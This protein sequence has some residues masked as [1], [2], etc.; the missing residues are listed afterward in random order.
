VIKCIEKYLLQHAEA[1]AA[2]IGNMPGEFSHLVV[3]PAFA[4]P[5]AS[6]AGIIASLSAQAPRCLLIL[7]VN[8]PQTVSE[9]QLQI[10]ANLVHRLSE[11]RSIRWQHA[12]LSLLE[13]RD[14]PILLVKR[15]QPGYRIA[16]GEG[17]G[18]ARK[19]GADIALQLLALQRCGCP[20]IFSTDADVSLPR[21]YL[22]APKQWADQR[23]PGAPSIKD[24]AALLLPFRHQRDCPRPDT[25]GLLYD[26]HLRYHCLGLTWAGSPY[27]FHTIGS[28]MILHPVHYAQVRGFPPRA[29]GEDFYCLNKL[30]KSGQVVSLSGPVMPLSNRHSPRV[31][32]GTGPA[33]QALARMPRPLKDFRYYHPDIFQQLR[34]WLNRHRANALDSPSLGRSPGEQ[35]HK[36]SQPP[37]DILDQLGYTRFLRHVDSQQ[38]S[39]ARYLKAFYHWFDG[40]RT[41]KWIHLWRDSRYPSLPLQ[42]LLEH[43]LFSEICM[44]SAP[45]SI[46]PLTP[47]QLVRIEQQ[48]TAG[49]N[50]IL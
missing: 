17:V 46:Q 35:L 28:L 49:Q 18:R 27:A 48:L 34:Q 4:E 45:H 22:Q 41:L 31:P 38:L 24:V 11:N 33:L 50:K 47:D 25:A 10:T 20:W 7:V 30:A 40:F 12:H 5:T 36:D 1:E 43:P 29:G 37:Q 42:G 32:F 16:D 9:V 8:T 23:S 19:I 26:I 39:Q 15:Y 6:L 3:I 21:G 44:I 13:G 14:L 2:L